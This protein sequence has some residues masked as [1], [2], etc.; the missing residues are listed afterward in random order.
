MTD[1][2]VRL[3]RRVRHTS[4]RA[5]VWLGT[6]A[7]TL[8]LASTTA[9]GQG[10]TTATIRGT[11]Q[12]PSGGVLPGA[13]VTA[14][15]TGTK[16]SPDHGQ[17]RSRAVSV[18]RSLPG[19]LRPEGRALGVQDLRTE[20]PVAEPERQPRHR[21]AARNRP[22]DRDGHGHEPARSD[23]DGNGRTRGRAHRETDRQ[24]VDHRAQRARADA[25]PSRR[26]H[27][28]QPSASRSALAAA[29]TTPRATRST[30]SAPR[31]TRCRSTA[32]RSSTSA[33]TA[34]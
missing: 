13:T 10:S 15:N 4:R 11:V 14:T 31:A 17:R 22:A 12:D 27:R 8:L 7:C 28:V 3:Y 6:A 21:R 29:A 32:R 5:T 19:H 33:A 23:S 30:G 18:R 25:H 34:A 20:G 9:F 26:R 2:A 16:G 1:G 24:P